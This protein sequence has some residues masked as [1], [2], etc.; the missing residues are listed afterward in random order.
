MLYIGTFAEINILPPNIKN[1]LEE[2]LKEMP[3]FYDSNY[4]FNQILI[5]YYGDDEY[6]NG[7]TK[8]DLLCE[9]ASCTCDFTEY[10]KVI[11]ITHYDV[12][13]IIKMALKAGFKRDKNHSNQGFYFFYE[14]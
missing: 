7:E 14:D 5:N 11:K 13:R 8:F 6:E 4:V 9:L 1:K 12:I 10:T 2:K 3:E